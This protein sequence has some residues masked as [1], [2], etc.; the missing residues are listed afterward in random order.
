[1]IG[2]WMAGAH[3]CAQEVNSPLE[4]RRRIV[5][6][7][8]P[9]VVIAS[10]QTPNELNT[11]SRFL[12][13]ESLSDLP[14]Q[15]IQEA[16]EIAYVVFTSGSTGDPKGVMVGRRAFSHFIKVSRSHFDAGPGDRWAQFSN[17]GHDL[18]IMDTFM[19]LTTGATLVPFVSERERIMPATAVRDHAITLWQSVPSVVDLMIRAGHVRAELLRSLRIMSFCGAP[20]LPYHCRDLFAA[21]PS[22]IIF[23]TYGTTETTGFNTFQR[24]ENHTYRDFADGSMALGTNLPGWRLVLDGGDNPIEG[25]ILIESQYLALGYWSNPELTGA[26]FSASPKPTSPDSRLYRTGDLARRSGARVFFHGRNDRQIKIHGNRVE[27]DEIDAAIRSCAGLPSCTLMLD[28]LLCTLLAAP[29]L[30]DTLALRRALK[31]FLPS[32]AIPTVW[33]F[34]EDLPRNPNGKVNYPAVATILRA[35]N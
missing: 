31:A 3:F 16:H 5:E 14:L 11:N 22:L 1:M 27:L 25:E 15:K 34:A 33:H 35:R 28:D 18:A 2:S 29:R 13:I 7:Y 4:R 26:R 8:N 17:I 9:D 20:L 30:P 6:T 10:A 21:H 23:N 12:Y 32:F 24:L 19:A